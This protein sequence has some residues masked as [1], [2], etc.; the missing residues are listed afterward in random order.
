MREHA[1]TGRNFD[2]GLTA[3]GQTLMIAGEATPAGNPGKGAFD[4][5]APGQDDK[6]SF[7]LLGCWLWLDRA[8]VGDCAQTPHGLNVPS[9]MLLDPFTQFSPVTTIAPK[10]L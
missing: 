7:G 1:P 2:E 3:L 5:P 10:Q 8:G 6:A 9:E 4:N